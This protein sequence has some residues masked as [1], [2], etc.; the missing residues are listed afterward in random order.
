MSPSVVASVSLSRTAS[1][2]SNGSARSKQPTAFGK[3]VQ[4]LVGEKGI[5]R[6]TAKFATSKPARTALKGIKGLAGNI[7][8]AVAIIA[9]VPFLTVAGLVEGSVRGV[10]N[11]YRSSAT[12]TVVETV[13]SAV[14]AVQHYLRN[15][16]EIEVEAEKYLVNLCTSDQADVLRKSIE[17]YNNALCSLTLARSD[18]R[19]YNC[20]GLNSQEKR[21][22]MAK[23]KK[24]E[25]HASK[26]FDDAKNKLENEISSIL[27][28][29]KTRRD[30]V[31]TDAEKQMKTFTGTPVATYMSNSKQRHDFKKY[32]MH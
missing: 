19:H 30:K 18:V 28:G 5:F 17:K 11:A 2:Q 27:K 32:I 15:E 4:S 22:V 16:G 10:L 7:G 20:N 6:T 21:N 1:T 23:A 9:V 26:K 25:K 31:K 14:H 3:K 8:R 29:I 24:S 12:G 13:K